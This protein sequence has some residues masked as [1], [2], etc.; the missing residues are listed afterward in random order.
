MAQTIQTEFSYKLKPKL[1]A[2]FKLAEASGV[3]FAVILGEDEVAQ[4]KVKIKEMGATGT[5]KEGVLVDLKDLVEEM[6]TR[7][8]RAKN[9]DGV[10]HITTAANGLKFEVETGNSTNKTGDDGV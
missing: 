1:P 2:Q 3:P 9:S 10:E 8:Q 5:E 6:K 7:L 4:G